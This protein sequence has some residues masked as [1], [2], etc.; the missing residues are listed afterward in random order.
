MANQCQC[1][2]RE[3]SNNNFISVWQQLVQC[4]EL[5]HVVSLT[6][7]PHATSSTCKIRTCLHKHIIADH[8]DRG[9]PSMTV[10]I[11][12]TTNVLAIL[13]LLLLLLLFLVLLLLLGWWP[14]L[15][16]PLYQNTHWWADPR[17]WD[18][19]TASGYANHQWWKVFRL[20]RCVW[21]TLSTLTHIAELTSYTL[22]PFFWRQLG[23]ALQKPLTC[24]L[25]LSISMTA[26]AHVWE[27][28]G[29]HW[30]AVTL[31]LAVIKSNWQPVFLC[32]TMP[33]D[34]EVDYLGAHCQPL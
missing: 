10:H 6:I 23:T 34:Y 28:K 25:F 14:P 12:A 11:D 3:H 24:L 29:S 19:P 15:M 1:G 31:N 9:Y 16:P 33:Y 27:G 18:P 7:T 21:M 22:D 32:N 4:L 20:F 13:L 26:H 30:I 2:W 17:L 5:W 8:N